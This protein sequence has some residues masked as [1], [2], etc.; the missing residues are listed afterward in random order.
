MIV[1]GKVKM[2]GIIYKEGDIILIETNESTD[3]EALTDC[4][5]VVVKVPCSKNDKYVDDIDIT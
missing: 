1:Y 3:F 5:N 4:I 2:N